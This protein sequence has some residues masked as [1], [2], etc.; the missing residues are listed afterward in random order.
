MRILLSTCAFL[1]IALAS[2]SAQDG[3]RIKVEI[4]QYEGDTL[5]LAYYL[6][7]NQYVKD[8]TYREKGKFVFTGKELLAIGT[9]III[10]P[11]KNEI[12]QILIADDQ[13]M[14]IS[15]RYDDGIKDISFQGSEDNDA[16]YTY[17][18]YI[19]AKKPESERIYKL[20][21]SLDE[22]SD[23]Y[24]AHVRKIQ[25]IDESVIDK[26]NSI[27]EQYPN[28]YTAMVLKSNQEIKLPE[29]EGAEKE[30]QLK[31]F[32]YF[33]KQYFNN[34]F[35]DDSRSF[36]TP[37]LF[38]KIQYY[39]DKLTMRSPDSIMLSIDEILK[40]LEQNDDA[41]QYYLVHFLNKYAASKVVG[42]DGVYV[43]IV[44]N[45]YA[46]GK[47]PWTET[48]QLAKIIKNANDLRASLVGQV[49][50]NIT[51]QDAE[52]NSMKV[53]D[54]DAEYTILYFWNPDCGH[55]K[56]STPKLIEF[57]KNYK[58]QGIKVATI[59]GKTGKDYGTCWEY[60]ESVEGMDM[61]YNLG[62]EFYQSKF[63]TV[64]YIKTTPK[65]FVLDKDKI[66]LSKGIGVEQLPDLLKYLLEGNK[67]Q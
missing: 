39:T 64:Y 44:D 13:D 6:G 66:I 1:F 60:V 47:A 24:Q 59:C 56:K 57:Y 7:N 35:L 23:E 15:A 36:R 43:H 8:T 51:L 18:N 55:C 3:Y 62:D 16:Y 45:Y 37:Q 2:L 63:K 32:H 67:P 53:H 17:I 42:H 20:M 61:F 54:I 49:A 22:T 52:G 10:V 30:V 41:F 65:I 34:M 28:S 9:Y 40:P 26:S 21:D 19:Q 11:P 48:E 12:I 50:P 27:I 38:D 33:K 46:N 25:E 14:S 29:F 58:D 5:I 4:E 31:R